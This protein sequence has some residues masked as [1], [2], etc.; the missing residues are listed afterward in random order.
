MRQTLLPILPQLSV[1][2]GWMLLHSSPFA[3]A[4]PDPTPL[5]PLLSR[6]NPFGPDA[7]KE[8]SE[9]LVHLTSLR[10]LFIA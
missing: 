5:R 6:G 4:I 8:I 3:S 1:T 9:S 7:A 10:T 2:H